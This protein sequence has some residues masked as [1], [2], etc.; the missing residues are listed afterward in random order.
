[1]ATRVI[2]TRRV[3]EDLAGNLK[4]LLIKMR[5]HALAQAGYIS[6]ET[7]V[8]VDDPEEFV[9]LSTWRSVDD[10]KAWAANPTR[11]D[12]EAQVETLLGR[13]TDHKVFYHH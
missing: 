13:P 12:L 4:P 9:V 2:I 5:S 8:N 7:L 3:P 6:G 1:M 10:W 11:R